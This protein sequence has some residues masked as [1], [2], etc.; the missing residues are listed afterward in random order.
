LAVLLVLAVGICC[1]GASSTSA[2]LHSKV[3]WES[4]SSSK[5]FSCPSTALNVSG[6]INTI[7][8]P[9]SPCNRLS[10]SAPKASVSSSSSP[11][12]SICSSPYSSVH[13]SCSPISRTPVWSYGDG[14]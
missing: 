11:S 14:S 10:N 4:T 3:S 1:S 7:L 9:R 2:N 5:V 6:R 13:S 12:Y 8:M